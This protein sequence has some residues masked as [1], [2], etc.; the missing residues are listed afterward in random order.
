MDETDEMEEADWRAGDVLRYRRDH[1]VVRVVVAVREGVLDKEDGTT[2]TYY[3]WCYPYSP[4]EVYD[5][6]SSSD[7]LHPL[8][9]ERV[10]PGEGGTDG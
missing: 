4:D 10:P 9:W 2:G 3:E 5:S 8:Y 7:Q 1:S 6:R